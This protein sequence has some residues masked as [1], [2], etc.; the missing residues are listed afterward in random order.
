MALPQLPAH[1]VHKL[2]QH[3]RVIQEFLS[4]REYAK[5]SRWHQRLSLCSL[6]HRF[7][8]KSYLSMG[9]PKIFNFW[10]ERRH[11]S[12]NVASDILCD[13][14]AERESSP[15]P[16]K[17]KCE[18]LLQ[19]QRAA[20]ALGRWRSALN[21]TSSIAPEEFPLWGVSAIHRTKSISLVPLAWFSMFRLPFPCLDCTPRTH[22]WA[23]LSSAIISLLVSHN[24]RKIIGG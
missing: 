7:T 19:F 18:I 16:C 24:Y 22:S 4:T 14:V 13:L 17:K 23:H 12:P 20:Y 15:S 2:G 21:G 6:L 1:V 3:S 9:S 10:G 8:R 11:K 5:E